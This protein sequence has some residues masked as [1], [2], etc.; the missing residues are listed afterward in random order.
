[1]LKKILIG[2]A[3]LVLIILVVGILSPAERT[4]EN[5]FLIKAPVHELADVLNDDLGM[6]QLMSISSGRN[7]QTI[8]QEQSRGKRDGNL[9]IEDPD[10]QSAA[11]SLLVNV[12]KPVSY[13]VRT[14]FY[15]EHTEEGTVIYTFSNLQTSGLARFFS[16]IFNPSSQWN[17]MLNE[18]MDEIK[19]EAESNF[20][21][22]IEGYY[23]RE[24]RSIE[25]VYVLIRQRVPFA[26]MNE[27]SLREFARLDQFIQRQ[28]LQRFPFSTF[29]Y[30]INLE[31]EITDMAAAVRINRDIQV[32]DGKQIHYQRRGRVIYTRHYGHVDHSVN[33]HAAVRV[34]LEDNN[35]LYDF[36]FMET[37][38][39]GASTTG[40]PAEWVT[41]I[42]YFLVE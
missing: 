11:A 7:I 2:L 21:A 15:M 35:L 41:L 36:P 34:Y 1:M 39:V 25:R 3:A 24:E 19:A 4:L 28:H 23:I 27:F 32:P 42:E 14:N 26:K 20:L 13:K 8:E 12:Y 9:Q 17:T 18:T 37:Y 5:E 22:L 38:E 33:A 6:V 29:Y 10:L 16:W 31:D 30:N 40:N